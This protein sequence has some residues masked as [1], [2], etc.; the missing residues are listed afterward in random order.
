MTDAIVPITSASMKIERRTWP[1]V[2]PSVRSVAN[3]RVR[4]AIVIESEFAITKL[5]TKSAMP[6]NASRKPRR[7]EMNEFGVLRVLGG[8]LARRSAPARSPGR[9]VRDLVDQ[10]LVRDGRLGCDVDLVELAGLVE[11][12]LRRRHVEAGKRCPADVQRAR[13]ELDDARDLEP[14]DRPLGLNADLVADR[15]VLV[16][17]SLVVDHHL[18]A[19]RPVARDERKRIEARGAVRDA[20]AEVRG[21]AVDDRLVV[22]PDQM[23]FAADVALGGGDVRQPAHLGQQRR[24]PTSARTS[25]CSCSSR[26]CR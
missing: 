5:P 16:L 10:L 15:E 13:A 6:P 7:N 9:T 26:P 14:H 3:S 19:V 24:L 18:V 8:L 23:R 25:R 2:A 17:R 1:R 20:E 4:C 22:R 21:A 11:Q 12:P